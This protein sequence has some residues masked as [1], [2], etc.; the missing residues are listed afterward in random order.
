MYPHRHSGLTERTLS[1]KVQVEEVGYGKNYTRTSVSTV[2]N[3]VQNL[4]SFAHASFSEDSVSFL[5]LHPNFA[6]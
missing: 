6:W 2:Q 3:S 1:A 5:H 4:E